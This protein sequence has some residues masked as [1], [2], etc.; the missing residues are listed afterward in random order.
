[1]QT[2]ATQEPYVLIVD[3]NEEMCQT[4]T[5]LLSRHNF[6]TQ[7]AS[8]GDIALSYILQRPP[9][10]MILDYRMERVDGIC[11]L[12][13]LRELELRVPVIMLTAHPAISDA[14]MAIKL[15][16]CDY[17]TKPFDHEQLLLLLRRL[18]SNAPAREPSRRKH[19]SLTPMAALLRDMG[20]SRE[21]QELV[22]AVGRVAKTHFSVLIVGETG[23]GKELVALAIHAVSARAAGPFVAVDC[24]A[25]SE[26]LF[27]NELFGHEKGSF[28]GA[29]GMAAGKFEAAN[30][31]TLFLDEVSNLPA[32]TQP[33]LLRAL[34][35]RAV[36]RVGAI[37]P[38]SVDLRIVAA[39]NAP[40]Q[41]LLEAGRFRPD[42][43]YRLNEFVLR[44]P[45]LRER[46]EDIA[47]LANRFLSITNVELGKNIQS[48]SDGAL[49][50]LS[51]HAWPGNVREL[52]H[53]VRQAALVAGEII[54]ERELRIR[55]KVPAGRSGA[56]L[57]QWKGMPLREM[58]RQHLVMVERRILMEA[59]R[60]ASGNKAQ[61]ARML[62]IDYKTIHQ[63]LKEYGIHA[64]NG[65]GSPYE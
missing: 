46:R 32:S 13:R 40:P 52:L 54:G 36:C 6:A 63:K 53:V 57:P 19:A 43:F 23:A 25:I 9:A 21:V 35:Q 31:G 55:A 5:R 42:L 2:L 24:G 28:T 41:A 65:D 38:L 14:V 44:V 22:A 37:R 27:E 17:L 45:A 58:V 56:E 26:S 64:K 1:M 8:D 47:Y 48:F 61:A 62:Q 33:K 10:A 15:G 30:G 12:Q 16:A 34:E 29:T 51:N 18:V 3:D 7:V 11:L 50:V 60:S 20:P 4:L 39:T 49:E 59:L